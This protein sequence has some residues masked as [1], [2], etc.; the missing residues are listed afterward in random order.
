MLRGDN[1]LRLVQCAQLVAH[2]FFKSK[3]V[4]FKNST[5]G[6][7]C[8]GTLQHINT[9]LRPHIKSVS[10]V[11]TAVALCTLQATRASRTI[12]ALTALPRL[13]PLRRL[14]FRLRSAIYG[15]FFK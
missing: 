5:A 11:A 2:H 15:I 12:L 7:T 4:E 3:E 1:Q 6:L 14:E 10:R 13:Q 9:L 8:S